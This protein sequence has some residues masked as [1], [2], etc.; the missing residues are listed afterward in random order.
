MK[1][2]TLLLI[3]PVVV[4]ICTAEKKN[5]PDSENKLRHVVLFKFKETTVATDIKKVETAFANLPNVISEIVGFEWRLNNSPENLN[6]GFTHCLNVTFNNEEDSSNYVPHS[7]HKAFAN[8]LNPYLEDLIV[9][10][11]WA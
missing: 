8:L 6:K 5:L 1:L 2:S 10:D 7:S 11:Y 4:L 9:L 3:T